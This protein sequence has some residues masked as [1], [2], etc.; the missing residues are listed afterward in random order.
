MIIN[1]DAAAPAEDAAPRKDR[2]EGMAFAA[3]IEL[4]LD[5][6]FIKS[7]LN[8]RYSIS[9]HARVEDADQTPTNASNQAASSTREHSP[10]NCDRQPHANSATAQPFPGPLFSHRVS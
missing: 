2:R 8:A 5:V 10:G 7:L 9:E 1:A 4:L 3:T 6:S